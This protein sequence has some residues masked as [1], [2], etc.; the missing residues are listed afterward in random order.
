M[1]CCGL[2]EEEGPLLLIVKREAGNATNP[3]ECSA[4]TNQMEFWFAVSDEIAVESRDD[5][6]ENS[7]TDRCLPLHGRLDR[8][9]NAAACRAADS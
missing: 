3:R 4:L 9:P 1:N 6:L 8:A 7:L 2:V 5:V